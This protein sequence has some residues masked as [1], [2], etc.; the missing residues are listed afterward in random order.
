MRN[1]FKV[2]SGK[3]S[4]RAKL[5]YWVR[6]SLAPRWPEGPFATRE[7]ADVVCEAKNT[8]PEL[9]VHKTHS[10]SPEPVK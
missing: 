10:S 8:A 1:R 4:S 5:T 7:Q 3:T 9:F 2:H 6:D